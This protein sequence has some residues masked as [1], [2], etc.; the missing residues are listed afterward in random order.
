MRFNS[1]IFI[2]NGNNYQIQPVHSPCVSF[3]CFG[4]NSGIKSPLPDCFVGTC[5]EDE[6]VITYYVVDVLLV[7]LWYWI[8]FIVKKNT[9]E[10][11]QCY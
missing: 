6:I 5:R 2:I 7:A 3:E 11:I 1:R 9:D 8:K 4:T 10:I